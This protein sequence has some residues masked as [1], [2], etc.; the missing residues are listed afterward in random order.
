MNTRRPDVIEQAMACRRRLLGQ[1]RQGATVVRVEENG[2]DHSWTLTLSNDRE[3]VEKF[4]AQL[5]AA[6]RWAKAR[7]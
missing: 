5:V 4:P 6:L 3:V 2:G 7:R 1:K